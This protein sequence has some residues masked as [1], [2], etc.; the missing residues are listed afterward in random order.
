[1]SFRNSRDEPGQGPEG[2]RPE[3]EDGA[4]RSASSLPNTG[5]SL[6][7]VTGQ[8]RRPI[9]AR[10]A[11]R[12]FACVDALPWQPRGAGADGCRCRGPVPSGTP[13][14]PLPGGRGEDRLKK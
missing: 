1:M 2:P 6:L 5:S 3:G 14:E 11:G 8:R 12:K 10:A 7:S 9:G 4:A 13:P